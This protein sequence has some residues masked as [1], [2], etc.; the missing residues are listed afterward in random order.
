MERGSLRRKGVYGEVKRKERGKRRR[1]KEEGG[2][3]INNIRRGREE[4]DGMK[5]KRGR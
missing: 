3:R 5:G 1:G 2:E 4:V